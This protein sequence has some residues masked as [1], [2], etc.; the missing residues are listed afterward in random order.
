MKNL[1]IFRILVQDGNCNINNTIRNNYVITKKNIGELIFFK[2]LT[3]HE[4]I[5]ELH[6]VMKEIAYDLGN[7]PGKRFGIMVSVKFDIEACATCL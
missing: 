1:P 7:K 4:S 3:C 5:R 2:Q 6:Q